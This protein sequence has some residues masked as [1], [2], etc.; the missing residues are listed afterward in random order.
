MGCLFCSLRVEIE[1]LLLERSRLGDGNLKVEDQ[2]REMGVYFPVVEMLL[3][4]KSRP[5]PDEL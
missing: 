2:R 3:L 4:P 1:M 5:D